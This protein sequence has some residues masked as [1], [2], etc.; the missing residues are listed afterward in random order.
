MNP[1]DSKPWYYRALSINPNIT[2]EIVEANQDKDWDYDGLSFNPNIT[3]EI[4]QANQDKPWYY[5]YLGE[6]T[7]TK[8]KN[9]FIK[10]RFIECYKSH[11]SK[12]IKV[13]EELI[14]KVLKTENLGDN[15]DEQVKRLEELG[16]DSDED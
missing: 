16:F 2:W 3:W 8:G 5:K 4:I 15:A 6:N 11:Y 9:D 13:H 7:M 1:K 12:V 14:A 10:K